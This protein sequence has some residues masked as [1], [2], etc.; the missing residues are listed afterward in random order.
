MSDPR[1]KL[2]HSNSQPC[3]SDLASSTQ[4]H[5]VQRVGNSQGKREQREPAPLPWDGQVS[6][7]VQARLH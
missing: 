5:L 6:L 1:K 7:K 4:Q 3:L 2:V